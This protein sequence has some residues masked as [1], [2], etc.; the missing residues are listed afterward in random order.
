MTCMIKCPRR[1]R[2]GA[3]VRDFSALAAHRYVVFGCG[4]DGVPSAGC[5]VGSLMELLIG[6][7][8]EESCRSGAAGT[9]WH[10]EAVQSGI[11]WKITSRRYETVGCGLLNR[12]WQNT[13]IDVRIDCKDDCHLTLNAQAAS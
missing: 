7:H 13:Q 1:T 2:T 12:R 8:A 11:E 9:G 4:V 10:G 3:R 5:E 6:P